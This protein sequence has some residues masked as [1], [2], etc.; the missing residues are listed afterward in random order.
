MKTILTA[1][2][3][4]AFFQA[5]AAA[6]DLYRDFADLK[7]HRIEGKD[8]SVT[9]VDRRAPVTVFAIHAGA[10]EPGTAEA[11]VEC[12]GNDWNLYVFRALGKNHSRELHVTAAHFDD[13]AAVALSTSSITSIALHGRRDETGGACIGGSNAALRAGVA[14][15]LSEAGFRQEEP[16]ARLP[17]ATGKNIVNR[18]EYGGVQ[19]ELSVDMAR[20]MQEDPPRRKAFCSAIR[21]AVERWFAS[22]VKTP[23][24]GSIPS[25]SSPA[26][27]NMGR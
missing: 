2:A 4:F 26:F 1:A 22:G 17:G 6:A 3:A 15:S 23:L 21:K 9:V 12:A 11:A 20:A 13:P 5:N 24:S 18:G 27:S 8:Y 10:I 16:C 14:A 19:L 7:A 25:V